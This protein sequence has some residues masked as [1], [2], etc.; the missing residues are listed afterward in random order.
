MKNQEALHASFSP[1]SLFV[2]KVWQTRLPVHA[3]APSP[4]VHSSPTDAR[5]PL[6]TS[7]R[8]RASHSS[9]MC[10]CDCTA[11]GKARH[12]YMHTAHTF[13]H[14]FTHAQVCARWAHMH[15][16]ACASFHLQS[17]A[18]Q[19][20]AKL[21]AGPASLQAGLASLRRAGS[22]HRRPSSSGGGGDGSGSSRTSPRTSTARASPATTGGIYKAGSAL[23]RVHAHIEATQLLGQR[24]SASKAQGL[25]AGAAEG[26]MGG[27]SSGGTRGPL[28][29][30]SLLVGSGV[31]RQRRKSL[32]TQQQQQE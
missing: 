6:S 10:T 1:P 5:C 3:C 28:A 15:T 27:G 13:S 2:S 25:G 20:A 4:C 26:W 16:R 30:A 24:S 11:P 17:R 32:V 31:R 9:C 29:F 21:A 12:L 8:P 7:C 19:L 18:P 22:W 14:I 23:A